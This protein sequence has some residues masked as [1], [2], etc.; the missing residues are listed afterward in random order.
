MCSRQRANRSLSLM[1]FAASRETSSP[2]YQVSW[3]RYYNKT[4]ALQRTSERKRQRE[5]QTKREPAPPRKRRTPSLI[6][7]YLY[8]SLSPA[9]LH[10]SEALILPEHHRSSFFSPLHSSRA[11][12]LRNARIPQRTLSSKGRNKKFFKNRETSQRYIAGRGKNQLGEILTPD[13]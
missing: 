10:F 6:A 11:Y 5:S 1:G 7:R 13:A 12:I 2:S 4:H 8:P 3:P 9:E